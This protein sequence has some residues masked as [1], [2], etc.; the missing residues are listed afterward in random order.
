M[1]GTGFFL[2]TVTSQ[3][4]PVQSKKIPFPFAQ[5]KIPFNDRTGPVVKDIYRSTSFIP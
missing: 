2:N 1:N 3:S 4:R 5:Q